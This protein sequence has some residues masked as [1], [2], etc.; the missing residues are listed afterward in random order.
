MNK[1]LEEIIKIYSTA[2]HSKFL[3]EMLS[4]SKDSLIALFSD[5]LTLYINDKNS[6]TIREF[7]TVSL[8]GYKHNTKKIGFNGFKQNAFN[9]AINCEAKPKNVSTQDWADYKAGIRKNHPPKLNGAGNFTDYTWA[10]LKKDK[11]S[12]LNMLVSGFIDGKLIYIL[13][14][15][16]TE[17]SFIKK[18]EGQLQEKFPEGDTSGYYLRS[19]VFSFKDYSQSEKIRKVFVLDKSKLAEYAE[20]IDKDLYNYLRSD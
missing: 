4:F 11:G 15:P 18:L 1:N 9:E 2:S 5:L 10:R 7:I 16:F 19:A 12:S 3:E 17:N 13:E 8:A 20:Y 14:F 6:S